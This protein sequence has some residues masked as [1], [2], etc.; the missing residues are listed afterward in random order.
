[1]KSANFEPME[2]EMHYPLQSLN[3]FGINVDAKYFTRVASLA[4]IREALA[5]AHRKD[6]PIMVLGGGSN[7]LF[8]GNY[9]G[10]IIK[11]DNTGIRVIEGTD[12]YV[13][14]V[15]EAGVNWDRFV[16]HC[17][18]R[19]WGGLEN[20]SLIP[21][22]VGASPI[23]NIGAYGME[24]RDYFES[25]EFYHFDSGEVM[26]FRPEDC[27]FGYRDSIFKRELKGKGIIQ[28]V[29]FRLDK[30]PVFNTEYGTIR[31]ELE[32]MEA[33]ELSL[34]AIRRAVIRIR[35]RKLPD[36]AETGN[37]GSFF[38]NP[39]VP[40]SFHGRLK[41]QF[42]GLVSFQ[43]ENGNFKLAAGWLIDQCGW[44]GYREGDTGVHGKQALVLVNYGKA[45]GN[46]I[47]ALAEKVMHSVR[48]KFG[49]DLEREVNVIG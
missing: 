34:Q 18:D 42:P 21:G 30:N 16:A 11:L 33:E 6:I 25:L 48:E 17:V 9:P 10:L 27:R 43:L 44:K 29:T 47:L 22:N 32:A 20:L 28:S 7:V 5:F 23:Q 12:D 39:E 35:Q 40:A 46:E 38:K 1:M 49:V 14:V 36:P 31:Q 37:A 3:T 24:M 15:A 2:T 26:R 45:T 4:E 19:G 13:Y 41:K 8:S